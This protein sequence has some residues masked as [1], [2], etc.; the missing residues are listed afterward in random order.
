MWSKRV[1]C[2][3][4]D[5]LEITESCKLDSKVLKGRGGLIDDKEVCRAE[6]IISVCDAK[7]IGMTYQVKCRIEIW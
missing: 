2:W 1:R 3:S 6:W 5:E 7:S 4:L